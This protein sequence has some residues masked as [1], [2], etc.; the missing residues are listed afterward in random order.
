MDRTKSIRF[1]AVGIAAVVLGTAGCATKK[2]V[3]KSVQQS[4]NP[5]EVKLNNVNQKTA[6]NAERIRGVDHR[7]ELGISNAQNSA[8]KANTA[9]T[10]A[11]QNAQTAQQSA[12]KGISAAT[13]AQDTAN[14]LDNY[15]ASQH[16]TI[17]FAFNKSM[18]TPQDQQRLVQLVETVETM[19]HYAIQVQGYTDKTGTNAY[20]LRLSQRRAN[21]VVRFLSLDGHIPLVKIYK[22]GY[23]EAS[24]AD[25]NRT[26]AGRAGNRRVDVTV[27]VPQIP[28][29]Q[30]AQ[31][32]PVATATQ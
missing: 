27:F 4:V 9:A 16:V 23:G 7:A 30:S 18:L 25:S 17:L 6:Q 29:Q 3:Q 13:R 31:A 32:A 26:R 20:N 21:A 19:K 8:D 11:G 1:M 2:Y 28:G 15:R 12:Q 22:L 10:E 5:L 14:N 24:P